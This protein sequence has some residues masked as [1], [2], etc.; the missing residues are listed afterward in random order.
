MSKLGQIENLPAPE[1]FQIANETADNSLRLDIYLLLARAAGASVQIQL[2]ELITTPGQ[3]DLRTLSAHALML[4]YEKIDADVLRKITPELL[5]G[6]FESVASRLVLLMAYAGS[7]EML[8]RL[9]RGLA[10]HRNR[11]VLLLLAIYGARLRLP[12]LAE[13]I[14]GM[15]PVGHAGVAWALGGAEWHLDETVLDN[16]GDS[17]SVKQVIGFM[18]RRKPKR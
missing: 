12:Q 10:T 11:R 15:L 4:A 13:E 7:A 17:L 1:L 9:M 18:Q 3:T 14:A 5:L 6:S 16:L 8:L 2:F